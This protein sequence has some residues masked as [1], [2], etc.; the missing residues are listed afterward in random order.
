MGNR[1]RALPG[2]ML[3]AKEGLVIF[4]LFF[5]G[6]LSRENLAPYVA[7]YEQMA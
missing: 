5:I 3:A 4:I 2:R 1:V 7:P 6:L